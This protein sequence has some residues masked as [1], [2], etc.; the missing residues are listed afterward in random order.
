MLIRVYQSNHINKEQPILRPSRGCGTLDCSGVFAKAKLRISLCYSEPIGLDA[1]AYASSRRTNII[2]ASPR[3]DV[4]P[5]LDCKEQLPDI[6]NGD[7]EKRN[8]VVARIANQLPTTCI[9]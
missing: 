9:R 2:G 3:H 6:E 4:K 8:S 5:R 1:R 7:S